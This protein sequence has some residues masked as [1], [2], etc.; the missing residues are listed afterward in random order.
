MKK[1]VILHGT[2]NNHTGN[3]FP[4]A[5]SELEK[6]GYEVWV[7]DLPGSERPN[8]ER[9]N[10]F[11]L[12]SG[13][14]FKGNLIIGHSAGAVEIL[15]LLQNLPETMLV[16]TAILVAVFKGDLG[17]DV[18][19]DLRD[20]EF[21]FEKIKRKAKK[22]IVIHSDDDPHCPLEGAKQVASELGAEMKIFHGMKHFSFD[23]DPRFDKFP[24]LIEVVK[25]EASK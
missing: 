3:W 20:L 16:D 7:P 6:L 25:Q 18:L 2:D 4:Y 23:T 12:K 21:D 24:E 9:Y 8:V 22:I 10:Q 14:D 19:R 11:L 13:W 5:K 1:A 15:A 17:W